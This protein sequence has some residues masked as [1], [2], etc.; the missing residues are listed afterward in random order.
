MKGRTDDQRAPLA[1]YY[2]VSVPQPKSDL[3]VTIRDDTWDSARPIHRPV[4][5][6]AFPRR[7]RVPSL[8]A[9]AVR[10][11]AALSSVWFQRDPFQALP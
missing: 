8:T 5:V 7:T 2:S 9:K 1:N 11:G 10:L 6:L 4:A 3:E